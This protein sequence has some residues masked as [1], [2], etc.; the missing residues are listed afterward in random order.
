MPV[1]V[2]KELSIDKILEKA[3]E[4][5]IYRRYIGDVSPLKMICS[6][7]REDDHTPS[8]RLYYGNNGSLRF[9]DYG[10]GIKGGVFDYVKTQ[11]P[12]LTFGELLERVWEDMQCVSL[13]QL[14]IVEKRLKRTQFPQLLV[15]KRTPTVDD[16]NLWEK[17]GITPYFSQQSVISLVSSKF[18][19]D[20]T[21]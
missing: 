10:T 8:F 15:N 11:Y 16:I 3:S 18:I 9:V 17:W 1:K 13:P 5:D 6:P 12:Y 21:P 7:L 4:L 2:H 19:T 14:P 20:D